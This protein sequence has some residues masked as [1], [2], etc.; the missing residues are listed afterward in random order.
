MGPRENLLRI[1]CKYHL[2]NFYLDISLMLTYALMAICG[3]Q[4]ITAHISIPT[5]VRGTP[6]MFYD[7]FPLLF[8]GVTKG[9][10]VSSRQR[11]T[12]TVFFT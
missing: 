9:A 8:T 1:N 6:H 4:L 2:P 11:K 12:K 10:K 7:I 3:V 5:Y